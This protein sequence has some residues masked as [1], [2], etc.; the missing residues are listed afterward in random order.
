MIRCNHNMH[1]FGSHL[2]RHTFK[3]N[4][5]TTNRFN[6]GIFKTKL[7]HFKTLESTIIAK[8][9]SVSTVAHA[10]AGSILQAAISWAISAYRGCWFKKLSSAH[11][12]AIT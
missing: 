2:L 7:R 10:P 3:V 11:R 9:A 1:Q 6:S 4:Q 12:V 5:S 8:L